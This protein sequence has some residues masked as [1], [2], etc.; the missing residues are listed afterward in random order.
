M[1]DACS[2]ALRFKF[3]VGQAHDAFASV[4]RGDSIAEGF[5]L[6]QTRVS[7]I[8]RTKC[9]F[10]FQFCLTMNQTITSNILTNSETPHW[11]TLSNREAFFAVV[12]STSGWQVVM[13]SPTIARKHSLAEN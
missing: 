9:E 12:I 6:I 11:I 13:S 7:K 1:K 10:Y 2:S 8:N 3:L 5:F 4:F